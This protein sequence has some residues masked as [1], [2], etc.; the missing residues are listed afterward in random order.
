MSNLTLINRIIR[1]SGLKM[2]LYHDRRLEYYY[3]AGPDAAMMRQSG[4]YTN[5]IEHAD[6]EDVVSLV[7]EVLESSGI[8]P[9]SCKIV[10]V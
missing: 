7:N 8:A 1:A 4:I 3:L 6:I 2:R 10:E 5:T 9:L